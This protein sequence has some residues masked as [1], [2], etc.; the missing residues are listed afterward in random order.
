MLLCS[1]AGG[2]LLYDDSLPEQGRNFGNKIWNAFRLIRQWE[3][4]HEIEQPESAKAAIMWFE[5]KLYSS[6]ADLEDQYDKYRISDALMILYRLFWDEFSAWYLESIKPPYGKPIDAITRERTLHFLD[7]L[8]RMLHPFM[9]FITEHIWQLMAGREDGESI[10]VCPSPEAGKVDPAIISQF[11]DLKEAVTAVRNIRKEKKLPARESLKLYVRDQNHSYSKRFES[12]LVKLGI[13]DHVEATTERMEGTVSFRVQSAEFYIP[14][15]EAVDAGEELEKLEEELS[16]TRG[17]LKSVL[18]KL[19][20]ARFVEHAPQ[21]VVHK[22]RK[23]KE[24]AEKMIR[25]LEERMR[26]LRG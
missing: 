3:V 20:N 2:D 24:D 8:I 6:L 16:Y 18:A 26:D 5:N 17:F 21:Q 13:L 4:D 25:V 10:M 15:E 12:I 11:E 19:E 14:L 1:Q 9:P 7:M 22:E 23:K